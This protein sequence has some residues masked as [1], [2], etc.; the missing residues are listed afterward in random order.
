MNRH[1]KFRVIINADRKE[2]EKSRHFKKISNLVEPT[3]W[4]EDLKT[5][6]MQI[7]FYPTYNLLENQFSFKS[8]DFDSYNGKIPY[9]EYLS[10][11]QI[12]SLSYYDYAGEKIYRLAIQDESISTDWD[13]IDP[14]K[15]R[16]N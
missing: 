13:S 1:E 12:K 16:I 9:Q 4:G 5:F 10:K 3:I 7:H 14:K 6:E 2:Y 15:L 11:R 8:D